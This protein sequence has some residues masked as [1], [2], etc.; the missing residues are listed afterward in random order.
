MLEQMGFEAKHSIREQIQEHFYVDGLQ[1]GTTVILHQDDIKV[2]VAF[3]DLI[4]THPLIALSKGSNFIM[5]KTQK[6]RYSLR[7][8]CKGGREI[9]I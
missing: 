1:D 6:A 2:H 5:V 7:L 4:E 8:L 3:N 9:R